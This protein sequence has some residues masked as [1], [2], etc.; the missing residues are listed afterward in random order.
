MTQSSQVQAPQAPATASEKYMAALW[1]EIIG[2]DEVRLSD[3]FLD[4]GGNSLRLN[5]ILNRIE[6][7]R[8]VSLD[9]VQFFEPE[10][11]SVSDLAKELDR[12]LAAKP[13]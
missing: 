7:E 1:S 8:G 5:I 12:L 13:R 4:V 2:L 11:S 3:E 9:A 10:R 6:K